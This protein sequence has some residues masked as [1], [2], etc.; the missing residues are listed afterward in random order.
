MSDE[1]GYND[2]ESITFVGHESSPP[3]PLIDFSETIWQVDLYF[4]RNVLM[5]AVNAKTEEDAVAIAVARANAQGAKPITVERIEITKL[6]TL[7]DG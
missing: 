1:H 5:F 3:E 6:E 2:P 4:S 7:S